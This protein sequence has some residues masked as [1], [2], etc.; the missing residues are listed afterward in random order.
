MTGH[1]VI[2]GEAGVVSSLLAGV[3]VTATRSEWLAPPWITP[4]IGE[5]SE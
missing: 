1:S 2:D 5:T 3:T 4:R